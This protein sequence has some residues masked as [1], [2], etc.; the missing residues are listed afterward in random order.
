VAT[1]KNTTLPGP[2]FSNV[3]E[4]VL[5]GVVGDVLCAVVAGCCAP[6]AVCVVEDERTINVLL[7]FA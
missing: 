6:L 2:V 3:E 4:A 1:N 7:V 5:G